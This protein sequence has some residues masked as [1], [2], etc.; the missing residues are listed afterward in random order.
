VLEDA[1]W[2][3]E[4]GAPFDLRRLPRRQFE[5]HMAILQGKNEERA[6]EQREV[7]R[8]QKKADRKT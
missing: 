2:F 5:A 7:E 1:T 4:Y 6:K 3:D 8:Q